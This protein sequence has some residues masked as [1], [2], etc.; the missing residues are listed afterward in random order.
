WKW[1]WTCF[2]TKFLYKFPNRSDLTFRIVVQHSIHCWHEI[3]ATIIPECRHCRVWL[4]RLRICDPSFHPRCSKTFLSIVKIRRLWLIFVETNRVTSCTSKLVP[5]LLSSFFLTWFPNN[6]Y[7]FFKC[8][9][10]SSTLESRDKG[11]QI[12]MLIVECRHSYFHI[13][14][15]RVN[16]L[17]EIR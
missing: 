8:R 10:V 13:R 17:Q 7:I 12:I 16:V 11:I 1:F 14:S 4:E 15:D 3:T 6:F 5:D 9:L 2:K